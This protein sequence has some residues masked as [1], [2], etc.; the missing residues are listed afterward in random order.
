MVDSMFGVGSTP[1]RCIAGLSLPVC[2]LIAACASTGGVH[3][4]NVVTLQLPS[5][6]AGTWALNHADSRVNPGDGPVP[7][8]IRFAA[9]L[10]YHTEDVVHDQ[11]DA[12]L[13]AILALPDGPELANK[14]TVEGRSS[15]DMLFKRNS[16]MI[17]GDTVVVESEMTRL[18]T[19]VIM[20]STTH[21]YLSPDRAR[22]T[23]TTALD[24]PADDVSVASGRL[25]SVRGPTS[26]LLVFDRVQ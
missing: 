7:D 11:T 25:M 2:T 16:V 13:Q 20:R 22:L 19:G 6:F 14:I 15:D 23:V 4:G 5:G 3:Q 21:E 17:Y 10:A 26:R 24:Y 9:S 1:L 18:H 12:A 8:T